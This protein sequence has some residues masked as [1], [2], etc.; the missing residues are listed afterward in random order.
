MLAISF[1][2]LLLSV[3]HIPLKVIF[4]HVQKSWILLFSRGAT[5]LPYFKTQAG[6]S[7]LL[8][9]SKENV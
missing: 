1:L 7:N 8:I 5:H 4:K 6:L 2:E 3:S 9:S